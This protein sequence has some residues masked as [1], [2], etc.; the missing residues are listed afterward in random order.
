MK[1][2]NKRFVDRKINGTYNNTLVK[3]DNNIVPF[4]FKN[5]NFAELKDFDNMYIK[6]T[7]L[8]YI[9]SLLP[10]NDTIDYGE[11]TED[12]M[13]L[14]INNYNNNTR[15]INSFTLDDIGI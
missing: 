9:F 13:A 10:M 3:S 11:I 8:N 2:F 1:D 14:K 15:N 7:S 12:M 5:S 6:D 4:Q